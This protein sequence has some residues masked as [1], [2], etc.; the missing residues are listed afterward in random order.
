MKARIKQGRARFKWLQWD[1][2]QVSS[3]MYDFLDIFGMHDTCM[4]VFGSL[5]VIGMGLARCDNVFQPCLAI[6]G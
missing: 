3:C 1:Y 6:S 4:C 5:V 2:L